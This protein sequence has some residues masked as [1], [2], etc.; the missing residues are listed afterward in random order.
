MAHRSEY[1]KYYSAMTL[2]GCLLVIVNLYYYV[3]PLLSRVGL[4]AEIA[5]LIVGKLRSGG[6]FVMPYRTKL[7]GMALISAGLI[8]QTGKEPESVG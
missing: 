4:T 3:H 6:V 7:L 2:V 8:T 1:D 5:D